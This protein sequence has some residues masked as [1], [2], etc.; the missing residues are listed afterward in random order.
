MFNYKSKRMK[1]LSMFTLLIITA[2]L[3]NATP[4]KNPKERKKKK[5]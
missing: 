5:L 4:I 1:T 2:L 3:T